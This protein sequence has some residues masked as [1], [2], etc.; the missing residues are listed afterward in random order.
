MSGQQPFSTNWYNNPLAAVG[1]N[2]RRGQSAAFEIRCT[3]KHFNV[4]AN[5]ILRHLPAEFINFTL[6]AIVNRN[7]VRRKRPK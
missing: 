7:H 3:Q 5:Q 2:P 4:F 6:A 1:M